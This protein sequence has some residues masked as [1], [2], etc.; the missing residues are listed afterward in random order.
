[1]QTYYIVAPNDIL[2]FGKGHDDNPPGR[3]SGRYA[4]GSG[5][6]KERKTI[7]QKLVD[8][9]VS[10]TQNRTDLT[11]KQQVRKVTTAYDIGNIGQIIVN[12]VLAYPATV[13]MTTGLVLGS[14]PLTAVGAAGAIAVGAKSIADTFRI[15]GN[16]EYDTI[17]TYMKSKQL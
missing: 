15:H 1:M 11:T 9:S 8:K 2:H 16:M 3:G 14:V 12:N 17:D 10:K 5:E 13:A 6:K 4:W 7:S